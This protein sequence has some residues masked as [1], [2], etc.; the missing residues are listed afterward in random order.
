MA[1]YNEVSTIRRKVEN[2]LALDYPR[3]KLQLLIGSDGSDD[4]T[5]DILQEYSNQEVEFLAFHPR[6]GK[7]KTINRLVERSRGEICVFSDITELFDPDALQKLVRHFVDSEIGLVGGNHVFNETT[8]GLGAGN[9]LF[10][11]FKT[12]LWGVESRVY[13]ICTCDGPI[14]ACRREL[15]PFPPED[16]INDDV[17][18]PLGILS[19][20][21]RIVFDSE[22][23]VRGDV[24]HETRLFFRQKIR[25]HAG[26]YQNFEQFPCLFWPWPLRRWWIFVSHCVLPTLV[27]WLMVFALVTNG[28][29]WFSGQG[30]YQVLMILQVCFYLVAA[31]GYLFERYGIQIRL[32]AI[33]FYFV[34]ANLGVLCGCFAYVLGIQRVTWRKIE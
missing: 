29:L 25:M 17:A 22:A 34:T 33:P 16:T 2:C 6:C 8:S 3:E 14:Y 13:S 24:L 32:T 9:S 11:K 21:K 15:F 1:A 18:V 20:G 28:S 10:R 31:V 23:I 30:P 27:P 12:V 4:G 5:N 19:R 26:M 7:M